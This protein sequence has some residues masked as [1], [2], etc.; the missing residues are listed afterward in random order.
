MVFLGVGNE[1]E[2]VE[3]EPLFGFIGGS[4]LFKG[5]VHS[6]EGLEKGEVFASERGGNYGESEEISKENEKAVLQSLLSP[7]RPASS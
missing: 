3:G 6:S 7:L 2:G 1:N 5:G 4:S